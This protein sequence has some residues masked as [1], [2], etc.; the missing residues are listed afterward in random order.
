MENTLTLMPFLA[1][2]LSMFAVGM[3]IGSAYY[4]I[5]LKEKK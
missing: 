5:F 3:V 4:D 2:C 1:Y